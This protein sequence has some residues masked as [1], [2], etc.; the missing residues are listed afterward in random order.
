MPRRCRIWALHPRSYVGA[1]GWE[2]R[3]DDQSD[4]YVEVA[5]AELLERRPRR[6]LPEQAW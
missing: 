1:L 6:P 2:W 5:L 4:L 3:D